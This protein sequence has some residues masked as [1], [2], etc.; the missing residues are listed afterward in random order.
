[1]KFLRDYLKFSTFKYYLLSIPKLL[2]YFEFWKFPLIFIGKTPII[3]VRNGMK[4]YVRNLLDIWTLKEVL[5]DDVYKIDKLTCGGGS[6]VDI[7]AALGDFSLKASKYFKKVY[8][9][10]KEDKLVKLMKKNLK[11]N[12]IKNINLTKKNVLSLDDIFKSKKIKK[13]DFLKLDCEG[14]EYEIFE[15]TSDGVLKRI[16]NMGM[17]I[18]FFDKKDRIR[19]ERLNNRL[20]NLGFNLKIIENP[21]HEYLKYLYVKNNGTRK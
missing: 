3:K 21:V 15:R 16:D 20:Q 7:G 19:F 2:L 1:M 6:V 10:E 8:S 13:C 5:F 17:E 4:F 11:L 12:E 14:S 18:H 9:F